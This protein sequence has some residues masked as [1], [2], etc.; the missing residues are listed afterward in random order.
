[1]EG[2]KA[3]LTYRHDP[4]QIT[5]QH[6]TESISF[7]GAERVENPANILFARQSL[8]SNQLQIGYFE[9]PYRPKYT[10]LVFWRSEKPITNALG[11]VSPGFEYRNAMFGTPSSASDP[12]PVF[13]GYSG[14]TLLLGGIPGKPDILESAKSPASWSYTPSSDVLSGSIT[15]SGVENNTEVPRGLLWAKGTFDRAAN[16]IKGTLSDTENGLSG[17]FRGQIFGPD[18]AELAVVFEFSRASDG[19]KF[20]GQYIGKR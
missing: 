5:F 3:I 4:E 14:A 17:T 12:L 9:E 18:R 11:T 16:S 6:D 15:L 20:F 19:A 10:A 1:M 7:T 2:E 13:L 8:P